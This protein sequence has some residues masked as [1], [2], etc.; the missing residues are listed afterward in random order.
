MPP[1]GCTASEPLVLAPVLE[2]C[3][4]A[5]CLIGSLLPHACFS[6][7]GCRVGLLTVRDLACFLVWVLLWVFQVCVSSSLLA[8]VGVSPLQWQAASVPNWT[9]QISWS[10]PLLLLH[11]LPHLHGNPNLSTSYSS[12]STLYNHQQYNP[13]KL[14]KEDINACASMPV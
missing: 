3:E 7:V 8:G 2:T 12:I 13:F 4:S 9:L 1:H 14:E 5:S 11:L 6:G 10:P